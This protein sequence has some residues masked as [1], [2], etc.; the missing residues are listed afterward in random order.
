MIDGVSDAVGCVVAAQT[1]FYAGSAFDCSKPNFSGAAREDF[2]GYKSANTNICYPAHGPA[3]S[4]ACP[5]GA[6]TDGVAETGE[7]SVSTSIRVLPT[8]SCEKDE[9]SSSASFKCY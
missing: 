9:I 6:E 8:R 1:N 4:M 5:A 3:V 2:A 7:R